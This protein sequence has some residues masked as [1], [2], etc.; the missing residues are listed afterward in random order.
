MEL[1]NKITSSIAAYGD[2]RKKKKKTGLLPVLLD[3]FNDL[4]HSNGFAKSSNPPPLPSFRK[5]GRSPINQ[6][7]SH[8][9]WKALSV[10][11][12]VFGLEE[13]IKLQ[14]LKHS[15]SFSFFFFCG[16]MF[17]GH[18]AVICRHVI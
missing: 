11:F 16:A 4:L 12:S 14:V 1:A 18:V 3:V 17:D 10:G 6:S 5:D 9:R 8:L 13:S 2:L 15:F 7:I